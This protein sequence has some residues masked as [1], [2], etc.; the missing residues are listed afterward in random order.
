MHMSNRMYLYIDREGNEQVLR[1]YFAH[2]ITLKKQ[3]YLFYN[4]VVFYDNTAY[5]FL[6]TSSPK[7]LQGS[8]MLIEERIVESVNK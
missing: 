5:H 2:S 7:N 1:K 8:I 6:S 4:V 3:H